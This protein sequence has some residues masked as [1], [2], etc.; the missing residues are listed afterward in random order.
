MSDPYPPKQTRPPSTR[1]AGTYICCE[2]CGKLLKIEWAVRSVLCSCGTR[3]PVPPGD[4][5]R[6]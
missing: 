3:L 5:K 6:T 1:Q 4:G 2:N